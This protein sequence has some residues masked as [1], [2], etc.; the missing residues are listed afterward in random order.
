MN[1]PTPGHLH[2]IEQLIEEAIKINVDHV[3]IILSKTND[4]NENPISC[5]EKINILGANK[6]IIDSMSAVLIKQMIMKITQDQTI[7]QSDKNI[8]ISRLSQM[9]VIPLCVPNIKGATPFSA[10][11]NLIYNMGEINDINLFLIIGDDRADML[12]NIASGF[13]MK[14]PRIHSINGIVLGRTDMASYKKLTQQQLQMIDMKTVPISAFSASFVRNLVKYGLKDKFT[15][16]YSP[17]LNLDKINELYL[18]IENGIHNL[19][20]NKKKETP[21]KPLKYIYPLI[22]GQSVLDVPVTTSEL[23]L[24]KNKLP[25]DA[26]N[27]P[28]KK[29]RLSG[30]RKTK[31]FN[32]KLKKN[33]RKSKKPNRKSRK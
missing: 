16:V 4:N 25:Y 6:D 15:D 32:K 1:P 10:L 3:Y 21:S 29:R 17:Y 7:D 28:A 8:K 24:G 2:L 19:P 20:D 30:G 26:E 11:G 12:D 33:N 31:K 5:S 22:K 14:N 27:T 9:N 18:E 23:Q 13:Y